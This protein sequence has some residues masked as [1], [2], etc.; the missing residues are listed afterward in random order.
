MAPKHENERGRGNTELKNH[1]GYM[2]CL[3]QFTSQLKKGVKILGFN[4]P[5][6]TGQLIPFLS[7]RKHGSIVN[8][9]LSDRAI[10]INDDRFTTVEQK[11]EKL[12]KLFAKEGIKIVFKRS[13]KKK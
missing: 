3:G 11:V 12:T 2:C 4:D 8:T 6:N 7:K 5:G 10:D 13:R 9:K 1:Q